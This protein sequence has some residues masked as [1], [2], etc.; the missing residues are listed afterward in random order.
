MLFRLLALLCAAAMLASPFL[1]W[2]T[3]PVGEGMV[4]WHAIR[5]MN[6]DQLQGIVQHAPPAAILFIASFLLAAVF[7]L[8]TLIGR[9]TKTLAFLT[10]VAPLGLVAWV[11]ISAYS[12]AGS[13]NLP[14]PSHNLSGGLGAVTDV[15][16]PG[17]WAW[18]GS[19]VLLLLLGLFDP[20]RQRP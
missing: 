13:A 19:A 17:V 5:A 10:G 2:L 8:M 18:F 7:V 20:G 3:P 12:R 6:T 9:E 11:L 16:G 15:L 1:A 14:I 4:P